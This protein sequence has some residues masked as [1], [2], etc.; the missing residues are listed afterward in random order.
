MKNFKLSGKFTFIWAMALI[1]V[2]ITG[3][4]LYKEVQRDREAAVETFAD[5]G[6]YPAMNNTFMDL[7]R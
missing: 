7:M 4:R 2:I 6:T 1:A 3:I 5:Q